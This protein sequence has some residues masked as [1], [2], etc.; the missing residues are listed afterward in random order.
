[1]GA[2]GVLHRA[3][4]GGHVDQREIDRELVGGRL[5]ARL[6]EQQLSVAVQVLVLGSD[7]G[8]VGGELAH[9][10]VRA[11][12]IGDHCHDDVV[13]DDL[14]IRPEPMER[15]GHVKPAGP[16]VRPRLVVGIHGAQQQRLERLV[17]GVDGFD[18]DQALDEGAAGLAHLLG[19]R[20]D[21]LLGQAHV[22]KL[23]RKSAAK[24]SGR[25]GRDACATR[26]SGFWAQVEAG[27]ER[28]RRG[29]RFDWSTLQGRR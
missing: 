15:Q 24:V 7:Q 26:R 17:P 28:P 12:Q 18:R 22:G 19:V 25:S 14:R 5:L 21:L 29:S 20:R 8:G 13:V 16:A 27:P 1:M 3:V 10:T 9:H 6:G 4:V 23:R 2:G 11:H